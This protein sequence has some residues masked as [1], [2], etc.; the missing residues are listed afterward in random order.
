LVIF[1]GK[2]LD[3]ARNCSRKNDTLGHSIP[4]AD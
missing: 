1:S 4:G 2:F 3:S